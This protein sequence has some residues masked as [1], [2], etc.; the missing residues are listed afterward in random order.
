MYIA[1]VRIKFK[2]LEVSIK[3]KIAD[4]LSI[5]VGYRYLTTL[6]NKGKNKESSL[7][8]PTTGF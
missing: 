3:P 7:A 4:K 2:S 8:L 1:T 6:E 5:L